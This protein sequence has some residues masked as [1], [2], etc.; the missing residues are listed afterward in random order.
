MLRKLTEAEK[1]VVWV[2]LGM[3]RRYIE[4]GTTTL[5]A[6]DV[7]RMGTEAAKK[8]FGAEI[9]ALNTDQMKLIILTEKLV[10]AAFQNRLMIEE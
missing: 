1:E 6:A 10:T 8:E 9:Q 4:T 3:R 5:S 7:Q 2:A